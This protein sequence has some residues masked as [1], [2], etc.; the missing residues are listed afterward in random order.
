MSN[1]FAART[2]LALV[3]CIALGAQLAACSGSSDVPVKPAGGDASVPSG[4]A[5]ETPVEG[6]TEADGATGS[7]DGED[8]STRDASTRDAGA[9][10]GGSGDGGDGSAPPKAVDLFTAVSLRNCSGGLVR[11]RTSKDTDAALVLTNGHCVGGGFIKKGDAIVGRP[12][13]RTFDLLAGDGKTITTLTAK[14]LLYATMTN[15]DVGLYELTTTYGDLARDFKV[16]ARTITERPP[17][18]GQPI[19]IPSGLWK[20]VYSC[21]VDGFVYRIDEGDFTFRESIRYSSPGCEVRP[22]TSGSPIVDPAT[23]EVVGVNNTGNEDGETCTINNPCEVEENGNV[24]VRKG[25]NYGQETYW[26]YSCLTEANAIDLDRPGCRLNKPLA[27]S[28]LASTATK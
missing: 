28:P 13:S 19:A 2:S 4:S 1:L 14:T 9:S 15:T 20:I 16:N 11:F 8:A 25:T 3:T 18:V 7:G 23:G 27:A 26:F 22:G 17:T 24:T 21:T 12:V 6:G 5:G 10:D